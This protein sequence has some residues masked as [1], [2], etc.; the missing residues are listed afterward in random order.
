ME[1]LRSRCGEWIQCSWSGG[2]LVYSS[3]TWL[4]REGWQ[5]VAPSAGVGAIF[6]FWRGRQAVFTF[7]VCVFSWGFVRGCYAYVPNDHAGT[8]AV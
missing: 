3:S 6:L 8:G 5:S 7:I 1:A 2:D 4:Y